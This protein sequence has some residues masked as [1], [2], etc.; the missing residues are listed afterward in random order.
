MN[1]HVVC[2]RGAK[3]LFSALLA[4]IGLT[5]TASAQPS[6][7]SADPRLPNPDQ[8]YVTLDGGANFNDI[9]FLDHLRIRIA[10]P[11]QLD[12]PMQNMD[13]DW[14]FDSTFD[15]QY[16]GILGVGSG[17]SVPVTGMGTAHA[18]GLAPGDV[19]VLAPREYATELLALDLGG[20]SYSSQF[21]FRESLTLQSSGVTRV[22]DP[23][24]VCAAPF[25][26]FRI[27]SFFDVF[28]EVSLDGGANWMPATNLFRI[29]QTPE[30]ASAW[31][32]VCGIGILASAR[33]RNSRDADRLGKAAG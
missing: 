20:N 24:L 19:P 13:G 22:E 27:S 5:A 21:R 4:A 30:P 26:G 11:T 32:I 12:I 9:V 6:F 14:E 7:I 33:G 1:R 16:S 3:L 18:V 2:H 23:C 25:F 15:I 8:P 10:N 29:W 17:P 31:L 28:A